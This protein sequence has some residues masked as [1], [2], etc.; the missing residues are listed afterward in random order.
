MTDPLA[1]DRALEFARE[2]AAA[3]GSA[4]RSRFRT[5]IA[6]REK[7]GALDPVTEADLAAQAAALE[8]LSGAP[9]DAVVAEEAEADE[10]M[11]GETAADEE[12][13][14]GTAADEGPAA[15]DADGRSPGSGLPRRDA[16]PDEGTAWVVDPIDGTTNFVRGS[17]VWATAVAYVVDGEP[18]AAAVD[19]PAFGD[20]YAA[21][22]GSVT[23]N[24][25]SVSTADRSAPDEIVAAPV[26]GT[27][28]RDRAA[29]REV[30]DSFLGGLGDLR[31]PG[32]GQAALAMVAAGELDAACSSVRLAPWDTIAGAHL[33]RRAGGT[34]TTPD[35]ERWRHDG[36]GLV[37]TNG[38]SHG[39]VLDVLDDG[40]PDVAGDA[41]G[42]AN[43]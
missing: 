40:D 37:A 11:P 28:R 1:P 35:G 3:G 27:N 19:L 24:G 23:R 43:D 16:V 15:R 5:G 22:D 6:A 9:V 21:G 33:V 25:E 7:A 38:S 8:A 41:D 29:Y 14:D 12:P 34:V 36:A 4:A 32:S 18:V 13:S 42:R 31:H 20:R 30:V 10:G 17:R 2:A 26:F 39:T